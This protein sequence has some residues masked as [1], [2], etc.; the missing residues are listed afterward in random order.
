MGI[1]TANSTAEN[2]RKVLALNSKINSTLNLDELLTIIMTTAAEVME[3]EVASLLLLDEATGELVFRVALGDKGSELTEKFRVKV[4]EGI[5]GEVAQ[6]GK[7]LIAN[8]TKEDKRFARRFDQKTGFKTKAI[9]CVPLNAK[10]KMIG[11]VQAINPVDG[12]GFEENDIELFEHFANQAAIALENAKL[13]A[14]LVKQEKAKQELSIA[15]EI[16]Q[17]F[18]PDITKHDYGIDL[19]GKNISARDVGGDFYDC[20]QLEQDKVGILMADVSGKGVPAA[21]LMTSAITQFRSI[22]YQFQT[23]SMLLN[24]LNNAL[25]KDAT[26]GMFITL[27]YVV[28][29]LTGKNP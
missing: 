9:A 16:Q 7:S 4:G 14:L 11:V 25:A 29:D 22:A 26:L 15:R 18:L 12:R 28:V 5:A 13:H 23:P 24:I 2:L 1:K 10:N 6:T 21:L 27:I 8:D 20:I 17:N 3:T 19:F